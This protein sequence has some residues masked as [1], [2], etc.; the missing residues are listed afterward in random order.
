MNMVKQ[1]D[2]Q[3]Q[4]TS[5]AV[6][7]NDIGYIKLSIQDIN[8]QLKEMDHNYVSKEDLAPVEK[9]H[10][11]RIRRLETWGFTAIGALAI[12]EF[13]LTYFKK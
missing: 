8:V 1:T 3:K 9:D 13:V 11:T 5:M 2:N 10:E 4:N 7:A 12:I 6:M